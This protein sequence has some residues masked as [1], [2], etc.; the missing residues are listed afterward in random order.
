VFLALRSG[1]LAADAILE[2]F[3]KD[4]F[5]AAQL[6]KHG[7]EFVGGMNSLRKLVYAF[8][9]PGFSFGEFLRRHPDQKESLVHLLIGNVYRQPI[10]GLLRAMDEYHPLPEYQPIAIDEP[11]A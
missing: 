7:G 9:D 6:G 1:E 3:E 8:Y 2:A 4:D 11:E 10:D 5:S